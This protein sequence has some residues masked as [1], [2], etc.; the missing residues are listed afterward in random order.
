MSSRPVARSASSP[1]SIS[2]ASGL[3]MRTTGRSGARDQRPALDCRATTRR[4]IAS[5]TGFVL[6][7]TIPVTDGDVGGI[8]ALGAG[9]QM[10][11]GL[12][13]LCVAVLCF[14]V[15][16]VVRRAAEKEAARQPARPQL[17]VA[18][19]VAGGT[20]RSQDSLARAVR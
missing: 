12:G 15:G 2:S 19:V 16:A 8:G 14:A 7:T 6:L 3:W 1:E 18:T 13:L 10:L 9:L 20:E 5:I 11:T 17:P 4:S